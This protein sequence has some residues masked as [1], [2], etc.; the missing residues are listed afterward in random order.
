MS[1]AATK[2]NSQRTDTLSAQWL[3][4]EFD[5]KQSTRS[6]HT[7]EAYYLDI[8]QFIEYL[9]RLNIDEPSQITKTTLRR[10]IAFLST[11]KYQP[12]S[13]ARKTA[14]IRSYLSFLVKKRLITPSLVNSLTSPKIPKKLPRVPSENEIIMIIDEL[15]EIETLDLVLLELLYGSGLRVSELCAVELADINMHK[16]T[17]QV[18][19]KGS[20]MRTV[21]FSEPAS[22][23][24]QQYLTIRKTYITAHTP[25]LKLLI[26]KTGKALMPRDVRR[27]L[28]KYRLSDGTK[29]H[30]HQLRHAFATHLLKGGCDV[31]SVQELLGHS[32]VTTTQRYTHIN[33]DH[34]RSVY[35]ETHPRGK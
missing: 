18:L 2:T 9:T 23:A 11:R 35:E 22:L 31:R 16:Q 26:K 3:L 32:N 6:T 13:I 24:I 28:D 14:S 4:A 15:D 10:Y 12:S 5:A 34:L 8:S 29:I 1:K 19:G 30:P 25:I 21:P 7:R 27:I 20:K 33:Q 17:I